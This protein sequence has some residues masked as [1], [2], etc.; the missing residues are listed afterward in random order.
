MAGP[1]LVLLALVAVAALSSRDESLRRLSDMAVTSDT[2]MTTLPVTVAMMRDL[3]PV[4]SGFGS[5][6]VMYR[7]VEPSELLSL[8]YLNHVHNDYVELAIEAGLPG[9]VIL[10]V[11]MVWYLAMLARSLRK[12]AFAQPFERRL[13]QA[14]AGVVLVALL[15]SITDYPARTPIWMM[16]LAM[17]AV[18]LA[19]TTRAAAGK[20]DG[21]PAG[22]HASSP[23][24]R[25]T[26][27]AQ[28]RMKA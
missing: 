21:S 13:A 22:D 17:S 25:Q 16:V 19:G 3:F 26:R 15:A 10:G 18:W 1:P 20:T 12:H 9:L 2:R 24:A 7:I 27:L 6:E 14:A 8:R 4:G 5:F 23:R 28:T 11:A